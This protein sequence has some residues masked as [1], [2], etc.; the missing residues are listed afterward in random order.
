M[1]VSAFIERKLLPK[2]KVSR[3]SR[4]H[5]ICQGIVF[6][7]NRPP[8]GVFVVQELGLRAVRSYALYLGMGLVDDVWTRDHIYYSFPIRTVTH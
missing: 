7:R 3:D 5:E 6:I 1:T 8:T 4:D 2:R